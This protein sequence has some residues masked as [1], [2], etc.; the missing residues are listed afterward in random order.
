MDL[1]TKSSEE[2]IIKETKFVKYFR[3][4]FIGFSALIIITS[5]ILFIIGNIHYKR[6]YFSVNHFELLNVHLVSVSQFLMSYGGLGIYAAHRRNKVALMIFIMIA[7]VSF[8]TR[9]TLWIEHA[10]RGINAF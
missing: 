9:I 5:V 3:Y 6:G 4:S 8:L 1:E 2:T 7:V 10:A